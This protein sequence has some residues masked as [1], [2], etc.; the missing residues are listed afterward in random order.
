MYLFLMSIYE[1]DEIHFINVTNLNTDNF[2][3]KCNILV[4]TL[5][6]F[7]SRYY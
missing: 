4:Y 3:E 5:D 6:Y 2:F 1:Y 7:E